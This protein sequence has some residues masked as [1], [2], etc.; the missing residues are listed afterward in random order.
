MGK[1]LLF[2]LLGMS[3]LWTI[4]PM[5]MAEIRFEDVTA[6]AG[7]KHVAPTYGASWGDLNND[8]WPDIWVG[9]HH[10][11]NNNVPVLYLNQGDGTFKD[12]TRQVLSVDPSADLHGAAWADFDNDGDQ[13]LIVTA[14][15]GGGI[16]SSVN[17]LFI[18]QNGFLHNQA[19]DLGV[20]YPLG[21]GRTPL[22]FDADKDGRLDVLFSNYIRP[23]G[24]APSAIFRQTAHGF[25]PA[26]EA[27]HFI[28]GRRSKQ[29]KIYDLVDN[30]LH[31]RFRHRRG[32]I[33][34][35]QFAQLADLAGDGNVELL[36][37]LAPLRIF[38]LKSI[39]FE[40]IT[41]DFGLPDIFHI[42]DIAIEDFNGDQ[43][44]DIYLVR[45]FSFLS[46][47]HGSDIVQTDLSTIKGRMVRRSKATK[48]KAVHFG[49]QGKVTF[50]IYPPWI[51]PNL[52]QST[53]PK[54][55]IGP[56]KKLLTKPVSV[57]L[58]PSDSRLQENET[59]IHDKTN[60]ELF[61]R[62]DSVSGVWS[63]ESFM[64]RVNFIVQSKTPIEGIQADGFKLSKGSLADFL[65]IQQEN[66]RFSKQ[67][68]ELSPCHSVAAGDFD[69]DMDMDLYLVCT[70]PVENLPNL[71]L[72]NTGQ[73]EFRIVPNSGGAAGTSSGRGDSVV[74]A[75]YDQDGFLD[76]FVTNGA[77]YAP[78]SGEGPY[79][80]FRNLGNS[81]HWIEIDLEGV[82]SNRDG[83]GAIVVAE[84]GGMKQIRVQG[85]GMHHHSQ[86]HKRLH[87][88]LGK[89]EKVDRI[90]VHWPS[91]EVQVLENIVADKILR[92][93]EAQAPLSENE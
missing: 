72:E 3:F 73:G 17:H 39:P 57:S 90:T 12:V 91:G 55:S 28:Y 35:D 60:N 75:D 7:I 64:Q 23:D 87:F 32:I 80:L 19:K 21:R 27:F 30:I 93:K 50:I 9:N 86:N 88:G 69:N 43:K 67:A 89:Y 84:T 24:K 8:G 81:N 52:P 26:N 58:S 74:F 54:L 56:Q 2:Y 92:I 15:G 31:F 6:K 10:L 38:S 71:L 44:F 13:D 33:Q 78:I 66:H 11:N 1:K 65:L 77:Y 79:Q 68:G 29:E 40:D 59:A 46:A 76:L 16:G 49:T 25:E 53:W 36:A 5:L 47:Q 70:G 18:N 63:I 85:G 20:E 4:A 42:Q 37:F 41:N 34:A 48:S 83:I 82:K 61:I 51:N 14:G 45:A 22:W 62:Y